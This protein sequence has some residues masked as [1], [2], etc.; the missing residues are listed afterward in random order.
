MISSFN[1]PINF[2][3]IGIKQFQPILN[4]D[5]SF[6][7]PKIFKGLFRFGLLYDYVNGVSPEG[8]I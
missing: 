3:N 8:T 2:Q 7:I 1:V 6:Y 4:F 5:F